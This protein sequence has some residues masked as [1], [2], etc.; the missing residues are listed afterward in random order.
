MCDFIKKLFSKLDEETKSIAMKKFADL[1]TALKNRTLIYE[2]YNIRSAPYKKMRD[3]Q[4][5]QIADVCVLINAI[6]KTQYTPE[7][8]LNYI[9][10]H[11]E[12]YSGIVYVK[13][14]G[15]EKF[16]FVLEK[17]HYPLCVER[18][19]LIF[20][21]SWGV[22]QLLVDMCGMERKSEA[23]EISSQI[24]THPRRMYDTLH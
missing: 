18:W 15:T 22:E 23:E 13:D 20:L 21:D 5:L 4:V 7:S 17:D 2:V 6:K 19:D 3:V 11:F 16:L 8:I 24:F 14:S 1:L 10:Q 9:K 12:D